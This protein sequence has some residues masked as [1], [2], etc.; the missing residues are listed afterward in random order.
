MPYKA[1]ICAKNQVSKY[2]QTTRRP[3]PFNRLHLGCLENDLLH[4]STYYAHI[5]KH[6]SLRLL[7]HHEKC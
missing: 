5:V 6:N 2:D 1:F 4:F 3:A 7:F